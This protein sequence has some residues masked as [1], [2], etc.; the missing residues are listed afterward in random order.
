M[1]SPLQFFTGVSKARAHGFFGIPH[2]NWY[3]AALLVC[4]WKAEHSVF[5]GYSCSH[6][7]ASVD[8]IIVALHFVCCTI[9]GRAFIYSFFIPNG[10]NNHSPVSEHNF[11]PVLLF[12]ITLVIF[13][14]SDNLAKQSAIPAYPLPS[15]AFHVSQRCLDAGGTKDRVFAEQGRDRLEGT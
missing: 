9:C 10:T 7:V 1:A 15:P 8:T 3:C 11:W 2:R 6:F 12:N 14:S 4:H 5:R 13:D